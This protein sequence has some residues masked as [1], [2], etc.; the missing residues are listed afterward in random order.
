MPSNP[1]KPGV[2]TT[3]FWV[4]IATVAGSLAT[5]AQPF[6]ELHPYVNAA[7]L[8]TAGVSS[9]AYA[10]SRAKTKTGS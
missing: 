3:E 7:A 10:V 6:A 9:A 4:T 5:M 2:K 8:L 1:Q